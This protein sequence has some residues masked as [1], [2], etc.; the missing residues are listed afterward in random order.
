MAI[1]VSSQHSYGTRWP[2]YGS[3]MRVDSDTSLMVVLA[4]EES[5]HATKGVSPQRRHEGDD[6]NVIFES[7][8]SLV[9]RNGH[10]T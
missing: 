3:F 5:Y 9:Y 7:G 6:A 1:N 8:D 10:S 4:V 2:E